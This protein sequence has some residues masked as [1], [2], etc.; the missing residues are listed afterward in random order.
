MGKI[1][2]QKNP[3]WVPI[4]KTLT[5]L[6]TLA[7][8]FWLGSAAVDKFIVVDSEKPMSL[9]EVKLDLRDTEMS[10]EEYE[11]FASW[12]PQGRILWNVPIGENKYDSTTEYLV[13]ESLS[14]EDIPYFS[15]LENLKTI[16][17]MKCNDHHALEKL[18][19]ALPEVEVNWAI[20]LGGKTWGREDTLIGLQDSDVTAA[21][22]TDTLPFFGS[23]TRVELGNS[24]LTAQEKK[25][26]RD[27][28]PDLTIVWTVDIMGNLYANDETKLSFSEGAPEVQELIA[29][30]E[31]FISVEEVDLTGSDYSAEDLLKVQQAFPDALIRSEL[32]LFEVNFTTDAEEIDFSGIEM[33]NTEEVERILPLM[34]NLKKVIMCDCGISNEDMDALNKRHEGVKFVWNVKIGRATVRTDI[35]GFIGAKYGYIPNANI[36]DPYEDKYRRLFD[37][38]CVNFKYCTDIIVMDLGHMGVTDYSF[39]EYMPNL[40]YLILADTQGTDFSILAKLENLIYLELFMTEFKQTEVLLNLTKLEN[41]NLGFL[42]LENPDVLKEMT[43]LEMLWIPGTHLTKDKYQEIVDALPNTVVNTNDVDSTSS[44]WRQS[45][46]YYD[47][48]DILD[49]YYLK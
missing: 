38:D 21:E 15:Y 45:Q 49:M 9:T 4:V 32:S 24:T 29:A 18:E 7:L 36:R 19:A 44:G 47:M 42:H 23:G 3:V 20:H 13:L 37:E 33:E 16:E 39:L 14:E 31:Q 41:L 46:N 48:R 30:A 43:W 17:A 5:V 22:L 40:K 26:L 8:I 1:R 34:K 11:R 25:S 12:I 35:T 10:A 2:K 6:A 27:A 28:F